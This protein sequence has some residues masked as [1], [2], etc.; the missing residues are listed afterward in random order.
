MVTYQR[1]DSG[2]RIFTVYPNCALGWS[3]MRRLFL[4]LALCIAGVAVW[5]ASQGAWLVMP[6][7]GLEVM[8]LAAGIYLNGRWGAT[9]EIIALEGADLRIYRGR[10]ELKEVGRLP[11]H[12][13]RISL[14]RDPRGWYPSRLLLECH[15]RRLEVGTFL[16]EA[17]RL[18]LAEDLRAELVFHPAAHRTESEP[19]PA[20]FDAAEQKI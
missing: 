18:R 8:V 11:R 1:L 7:A 10:R 4:F 9:R 6:F 13:S 16:I 15:G 3:W 17:E 14:L 5:F 19:I 12:W 20:G 2:D